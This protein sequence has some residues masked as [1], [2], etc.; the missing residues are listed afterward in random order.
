MAFRERMRRYDEMMAGPDLRDEAH[1]QTCMRLLAEY[2]LV[3]YSK[4]L[5]TGSI[6]EVDDYPEDFKGRHVVLPAHGVSLHFT[7]RGSA[8]FVEQLKD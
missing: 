5:V 8:V 2:L 3:M 6:C 4:F 1:L 7:N